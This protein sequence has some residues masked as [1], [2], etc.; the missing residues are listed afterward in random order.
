ETIRK[1]GYRLLVEPVTVEHERSDFTESA[2]P[3]KNKPNAYAFLI[4]FSS[5]L[6][7]IFF[8]YWLYIADNKRVEQ[9]SVETVTSDPGEELYVS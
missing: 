1:V 2:L 8:I 9:L 3:K 6:M 7:F 4:K 5:L